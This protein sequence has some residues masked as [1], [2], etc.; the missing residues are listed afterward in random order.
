MIEIHSPHEQLKNPPQASFSLSKISQQC[1][2]LRTPTRISKKLQ[3]RTG[4]AL[5]I[6]QGGSV[7]LSVTK[8]PIVAK[9]SIE[10]R[11]TSKLFDRIEGTPR[12]SLGLTKRFL[13]CDDSE[14]P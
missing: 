4:E 5:M 8:L 14:R 10:Q 11:C 7:R 13:C 1:Q 12:H 6:A 3:L 9:Q 2:K